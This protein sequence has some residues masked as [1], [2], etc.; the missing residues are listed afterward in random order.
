MISRTLVIYYPAIRALYDGMSIAH[1]LFVLLVVRLT[2]YSPPHVLAQFMFSVVLDFVDTN[3][4]TFH[5]RFNGSWVH[6]RRF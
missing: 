6:W 1:H 5:F 3:L 4:N 2:C